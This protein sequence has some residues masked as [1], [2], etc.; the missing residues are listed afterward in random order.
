MNNAAEKK[1]VPK[2]RVFQ[3][4]KKKVRIRDRNKYILGHDPFLLKLMERRDGLTDEE[5]SIV[6]GKG[7]VDTRGRRKELVNM[8]L[9]IDSGAYRPSSAGRKARVWRLTESGIVKAQ[10]I[11]NRSK[12]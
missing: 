6:V 4:E 8:G 1:E 11:L 9:V 5:L 7:A 2:L 12:V 3:P 10:E